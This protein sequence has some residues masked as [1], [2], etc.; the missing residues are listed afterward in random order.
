MHIQIEC[1]E[2]GSLVPIGKRI[3]SED[4]IFTQTKNECHNNRMKWH[5]RFGHYK[6]QIL[7]L[8]KTKEMVNGI[9]NFISTLP[10]CKNFLYGKQ[11]KIKFLTHG[12]KKSSKHFGTHPF[13]CMWLDEG[14]TLGGVKYFFTFI[15]NHYKFTTIYVL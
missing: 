7:K 3:T 2:E 11:Q 12:G 13:G 6:L 10:F 9:N 5:L 4:P 1:M 14:T 8:V 15:E